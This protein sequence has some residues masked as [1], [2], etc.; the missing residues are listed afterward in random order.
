M[1]NVIRVCFYNGLN[2]CNHASF[3][4]QTATNGKVTAF[5]I[6]FLTPFI[7]E[8]EILAL[9]KQIAGPATLEVFTGYKSLPTTAGCKLNEHFVCAIKEC[10][11]E[12]AR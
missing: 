8:K 7:V 3:D 10:E 6:G 11:T 5:S 2:F 4:L 9:V 1:K 12:D